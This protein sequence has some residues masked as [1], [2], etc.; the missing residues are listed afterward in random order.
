LFYF[1]PILTPAEA[2]QAFPHGEAGASENSPAGYFS[3][4]ACLPRWATLHAGS[5]AKP[6]HWAGS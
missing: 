5:F 3:E 6:A 2:G 1:T 4:Q